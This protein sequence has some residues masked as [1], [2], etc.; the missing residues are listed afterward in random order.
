MILDNKVLSLYGVYESN[1]ILLNLEEYVSGF[2]WL[3]LS[4][5]EM[6][7]KIMKTSSPKKWKLR[8]VETMSRFFHKSKIH[9][10]S[11]GQSTGYDI[12]Q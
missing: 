8:E 1:Y 3:H 9:P 12:R 5:F 4:I 10:F 7:K 11:I 6:V 2:E